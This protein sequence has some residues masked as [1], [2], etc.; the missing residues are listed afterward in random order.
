M[1]RRWLIPPICRCFRSE[2]ERNG[3]NSSGL[4]EKEKTPSSVPA[5]LLSNWIEV[6]AIPIAAAIME[7]QPI[8]LGLEVIGP[9]L[10]GQGDVQIPSG[11]SITLSLL[12]MQ[13][14]A[15]FLQARRGGGLLNAHGRPTL[16]TLS[17]VPI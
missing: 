10:L 9:R 11:L 7:T 6:F 16:R 2:E 4:L 3:M 12:I 13:W 5:Q 15:M 17:A 8:L 14:W 1:V